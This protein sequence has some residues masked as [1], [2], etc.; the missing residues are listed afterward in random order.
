MGI[1]MGQRPHGHRV[2]F[3][4]KR[5]DHCRRVGSKHFEKHSGKRLCKLMLG[6][7]RS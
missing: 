7:E 3:R 6:D 1:A 5:V 2:C 4:V